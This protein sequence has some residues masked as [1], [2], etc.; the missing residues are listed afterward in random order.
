MVKHEDWAMPVQVGST[1]G[2]C[3]ACRRHERWNPHPGRIGSHSRTPEYKP[4]L[5]LLLTMVLYSSLVV[6]LLST[7]PGARAEMGYL[8]EPQLQ[9]LQQGEGRTA[10]GAQEEWLLKGAGSTRWQGRRLQDDDLFPHQDVCSRTCTESPW[11]LVGTTRTLRGRSLIVFCLKLQS[12]KNCTASPCCKSLS[13]GIDAVSISVAATGK[14]NITSVARVTVGGQ[15]LIRYDNYPNQYVPGTP[16]D[17]GLMATDLSSFGRTD[18]LEICYET[19]T[20]C[21]DWTDLCRSGMPGATE[22]C[23][24]SVSESNA[25]GWFVCCN[26]CPVGPLNFTT[27]IYVESPPPPPSP[28]PPAPRRRPPSPPRRP[29]APPGTIP[30]PPP[31]RPQVKPP[32][33]RTKRSPPPKS[34]PKPPPPKPSPKSPP[35]P[36]PRPSPRPSNPP[37]FTL[38][39]RPNPAPPRFPAPPRSPAQPRPF[40]SPSVP[41]PPSPII[42]LPTIPSPRLS[43]P[44]GRPPSP[45]PYPFPNPIVAPLPSPPPIQTPSPPPKP[46][47]LPSPS[48]PPRSSPSP[49]FYLPNPPPPSPPPP[50]PPPPSTPSNPTLNATSVSQQTLPSILTSTPPPSLNSG[51]ELIAYPSPLPSPAPSAWTSPPPSPQPMVSFPPSIRS[52]P[53]DSLQSGRQPPQVRVMQTPTDSLFITDSVSDSNPSPPSYPPTQPALP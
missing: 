50:S 8:E 26:S 38:S 20:T 16:A 21:V 43:V 14:C 45:A 15:T 35:G 27:V 24:F 36:P 34:K 39:P 1:S 30:S 2:C 44:P 18:N 6:Q 31:P 23:R 37:P 52:T 5:L 11:T 29:P 9:A 49:S 32:P 53:T 10:T 19:R 17:V 48:P 22:G 4:L 12:R 40:V 13:A 42:A 25:D 47:S 3:L 41:R 7:L 28:R 46:Y 33:P 51:P